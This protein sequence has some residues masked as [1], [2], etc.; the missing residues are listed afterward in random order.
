VAGESQL[1]GYH[2]QFPSVTMIDNKSARPNARFRV[3][4][5]LKENFGPG[6]TL[7]HTMSDTSDVA[8]QAFVTK[9]GRRL[10][11]VN[12]RDRVQQVALPEDARHGG[13]IMVAPSTDDDP[14]KQTGDAGATLSLEP[15]EVAVVA[16]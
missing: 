2:T 12:K 7:V 16:Y 5:L 11:L 6:D 8:A 1:V 4:E 15:F 14:P 10:L 3:L 9:R 13:V